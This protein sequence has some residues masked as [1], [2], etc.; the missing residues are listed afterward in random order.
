MCDYTNPNL[1]QPQG[2][3]ADMKN[4]APFWNSDGLI[5]T[6][7][8]LPLPITGE[9]VWVARTTRTAFWPRIDDEA[10]A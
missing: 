3:K 4:A 8:I 9:I 2:L 5:C 6:E 10:N 1:Q 7:L